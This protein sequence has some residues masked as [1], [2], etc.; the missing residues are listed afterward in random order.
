MLD[1]NHPMLQVPDD[2]PW[3]FQGARWAVASVDHM[4]A[5][6]REVLSNPEVAAI[7]GR[8]ARERMVSKYSPDALAFILSKEFARV[9]DD[10]RCAMRQR[11]R[12]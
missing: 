4:R 9:K 6:M 7:K 12:G 5:R 11:V 2:Q 1:N 10:I 8:R 3:W